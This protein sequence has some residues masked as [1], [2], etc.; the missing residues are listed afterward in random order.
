MPPSRPWRIAHTEASLGWGGQE[1]RI[2]TE[3]T[4]LRA[5]GHSLMLAA[6]AASRVH[7]Q[8]QAAGFPVFPLGEGRLSF[9]FT[10]FRLSR[11]LKLEAVEVLNP[12][13]SR[14]GWI[15]GLAGRLAGVP[16]IVRSRHFE[17]PIAS[18]ALSRLVYTRLADHLITTSPSI[19]AQFQAAFDLPEARI[20]TVPTGID[21]SVFSRAG[22]R[23]E[24][25]APAGQ[26]G[27]PVIGM[28]AVLRTAKGHISL[29]LAARRLHDAGLPVRLVFAGD[30]PS[31][32]PIEEEIVRQRLGHC[33]Q[34]LGHREDVPE[35]LRA[36]DLL[37]IPSTHEGIPQ[38]A[39]QAL[40]SEVP[41][42]GSNVGGIPSVIE[43][44]RT[45]RL[46]PAGNE[47]ALAET[48]RAALTQA[49]ATR[50]MAEEGRRRVVER[51]SV[52]V[53]ADALEAIYRRHLPA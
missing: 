5:R 47:A 44:G 7:S 26:A 6:P 24:L 20:S 19:T 41:V 32:R 1:M 37:A 40:A 43:D 15:A 49:T 38:V 29:V 45:G 22:A 52:A 9:P 42:V 17:V 51:H 4:A 35:L 33:V 11:F 27:W 46:F 12:H 16:F 18:P 36:L 2:L 34:F 53:M 28:I 25:P 48:L 10:V 3:M 30:G 8:A 39:L 23:A 21:P 50:A 14:D 31:R 13:S